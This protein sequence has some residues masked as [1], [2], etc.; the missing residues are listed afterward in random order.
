MSG[1]YIYLYSI[2]KVL[3]GFHCVPVITEVIFR[4]NKTEIDGNI[5]DK[6]D[7]V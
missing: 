2:V 5:M 3:S 4:R 7:E 6:K 1:D